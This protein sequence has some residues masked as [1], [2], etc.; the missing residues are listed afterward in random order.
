MP[1]LNMPKTEIR[2]F[3]N[4]PVSVMIACGP[5]TLDSNL[6]YEPFNA[7]MNH[8][9]KNRPDVIIL[10]SDVFNFKLSKLLIFIC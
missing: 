1:P 3:S 2:D 7:L 6:N 10:V 4:T 9:E 8:V 5:Y